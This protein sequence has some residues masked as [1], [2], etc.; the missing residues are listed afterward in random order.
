LNFE[1]RRSHIKTVMDV[2]TKKT[3]KKDEKKRLR[4]YLIYMHDLLHDGF[5]FFISWYKH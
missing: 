5:Y 3:K 2:T 1:H 4:M